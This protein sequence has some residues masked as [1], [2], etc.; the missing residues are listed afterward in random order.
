MAVTTLS[1][2]PAIRNRLK[3]YGHAGMTYDEILTHMMDRIDEE[4]FVRDLRRRADEADA[5]GTWV[6]LDDV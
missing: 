6:D 2:S 5:K 1:L 3:R 4:E